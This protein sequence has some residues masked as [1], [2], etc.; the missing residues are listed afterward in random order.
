MV[1]NIFFNIFLILIILCFLKLAAYYIRLRI[2]RQIEQIID[3]VLFLSLLKILHGP[4]SLDSPNLVSIIFPIRLNRSC[5][6]NAVERQ[7]RA[8]IDNFQTE[9]IHLD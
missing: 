3:L 5:H 2:W 7:K 8:F 9:L 1:K 6:G 4:S